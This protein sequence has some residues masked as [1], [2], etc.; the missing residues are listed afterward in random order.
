MHDATS[1]IS[2]L[3]IAIALGVPP[4]HLS[5][6]LALQREEE[7]EVILSF[8]Q[9]VNSDLASGLRDGRYDVG[10]SPELLRIYP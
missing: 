6:L 3:K 5:A 8:F 1:Q 7:P 9:V 10:L 2:S 4:S